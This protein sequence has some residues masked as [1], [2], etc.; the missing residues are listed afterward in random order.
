MTVLA[1]REEA[2]VVA[3]QTGASARQVAIQFGVGDQ[4]VRRLL[5]ARGIPRRAGQPSG[6]SMPVPAEPG[7]DDAIARLS[8][9][10]LAYIAGLIDGEG[11]LLIYRKKDRRGSSHFR[12]ILRISNTSQRVIEWLQ[13][14]LG[15][16]A[17]AGQPSS[18]NHLL[19]YHWR[20]EGPRM[21]TLLVATCPYLVIK[22]EL[23]DLLISMQMMLTYSSSG[24]RLPSEAVAER[25]SMFEK[26]RAEREEMKGR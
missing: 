23:A 17:H 15:G 9:A 20:C 24:L 26:Y 8:V 6:P 10:E 11:C 7:A 3:Y 19:V 5:D 13:T 25:E 4:T 12:C 22:P 21:A 16:G 14:R 2:V 18:S 1:G